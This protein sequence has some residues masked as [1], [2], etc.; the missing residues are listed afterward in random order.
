MAE[1]KTEAETKIKYVKVCPT[2]GST[3][4]KR[5][6]SDPFYGI[7]FG[8]KYI[9]QNCKSRATPLE[10]DERYR[11]PVK[12]PEKKIRLPGEF[13]VGTVGVILVILFAAFGFLYMFQRTGNR[14]YLFFSVPFILGLFL[15]GLFELKNRIKK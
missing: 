1:K 4:L 15:D 8:S 12:I 11:P 3:D 14:I 5:H 10:V 13:E 7:G 9:C 2:C 6:K